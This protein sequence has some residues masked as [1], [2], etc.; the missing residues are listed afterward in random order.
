[1]DG[2]WQSNPVLLHAF[3]AVIGYIFCPSLSSCRG[4]ESKGLSFAL[5]GPH[6]TRG[7][8]GNRAMNSGKDCVTQRPPRRSHHIV[9]YGLATIGA[10]AAAFAN[11]VHERT[12][13]LI[14]VLLCSVSLIFLLLLVGEVVKLIASALR[15]HVSADLLKGLALSVAAL[16]LCFFIV[17]GTLGLLA[18]RPQNASLAQTASVYQPTMPDEWKRRDVEIPGATK[19][20]YWHGVLHV[21]NADRMRRTEP[22]PV[23]QPS[24]FRIMVVGDSLTYGQGVAEELTY[25][26]VVERALQSTYRCEVLNLGVCGQNSVKVKET[27]EKFAPL[28]KPNLIVYGICLNDFLPTEKQHEDGYPFPL[29]EAVKRAMVQ[30]TRFGAFLER[31]YTDLLRRLGLMDS[32][33]DKILRFVSWQ[34]RFV[35]DL[36]DM[37]SFAKD[38][39]FGQII[40]IALDQWPTEKRME[41]AKLV[42]RYAA[43][44]DMI[45]LPTE[46]FQLEYRDRGPAELV[47]SR[48]EL[49]PNA[50]AHAIY[51]GLLTSKIKELPVLGACRTEH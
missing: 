19:A 46:E 14:D 24:M 31:E 40:A 5:S 27:L 21:Y 10:M 51:A 30:H 45:V 42:E 38:H 41:I 2:Q 12:T 47:V 1:M 6:N 25:P 43:Q 15:S 3:L 4:R 35:S 33:E 50:K 22:W 34:E 20:Y 28:L 48:W 39:G 37:S 9:L 8:R 13:V 29:P 32:M 23:R 7:R 44:A 36:K 16:C 18:K 11:S 26:R 49:H 17:E